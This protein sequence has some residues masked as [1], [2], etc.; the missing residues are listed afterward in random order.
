MS[1]AGGMPTFMVIGAAE[2][3]PELFLK[4]PLTNHTAGVDT[5]SGPHFEW[6][7]RDAGCDV[8]AFPQR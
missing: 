1:V 6:P 7:S 2:R 3:K 4:I 8:T 5:A